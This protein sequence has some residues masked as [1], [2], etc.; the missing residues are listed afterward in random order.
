[1][2]SVIGDKDNGMYSLIPRRHVRPLFSE[3]KVTIPASR[4]AVVRTDFRML[5][6]LRGYRAVVASC[7]EGV[8]LRPENTLRRVGK[9]YLGLLEEDCALQLLAVNNNDF[10]IEFNQ[11]ESFGNIGVEEEEDE[12]W[13]ERQVQTRMPRRARLSIENAVLPDDIPALFERFHLKDYACD[14]LQNEFFWKECLPEVLA[15]LQESGWPLHSHDDGENALAKITR[16]IDMEKL[17]EF[18]KGSCC[19]YCDTDTAESCLTNLLYWMDIEE[20]FPTTKAGAERA[21]VPV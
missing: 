11:Y 4:S 7:L 9:D 18:L 6:L 20:N 1:M 15:V 2:E 8:D 3:K 12:G 10:D 13:V 17:E 21:E 16:R 19:H 5:A 14:T